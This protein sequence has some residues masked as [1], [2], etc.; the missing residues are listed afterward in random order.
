MSLLASFPK[1]YDAA[2]AERRWTDRWDELGIHR[3]QPASTAAKAGKVFSVDTPPPYVSAAHLHVG[4]AMSYSQAEF[5]VRFQRMRG[6]AVFYPMGFDDNGLPTERYVEQKHKVNKAKVS[7]A[8]FIELCLQETRLG[9]QVYKD[10]WR[11]L[12]L[13]VDWRMTYS[14]IQPRAVRHAQRSFLDLVRQGRMERRQD[15]ILWC[16]ACS[17]ALAQAD[18]EADDEKDR[19]MHAVRFERADGNGDG[20]IETTRPE[21]VPACVA[22]ACHPDDARFKGFAGLR[23]HVPLT[24]RTVPLIRDE[25]VDPEFGTGLMMVCTFGDPEDIAK[26]RKYG[27]ETVLIIDAHGRMVIPELPELHGQR[28]HVQ[29]K[30]SNVYSE[31]RAAAV[32]LLKV[33]GHLL[34]IKG[35]LSRASLHERCSTPVEIQVAPQWFIRLLDL[36]DELLGRGRELRWYPDWMRER[37]ENWVENLRWDW[38]I[39]RQRFYGVPFPVWFCEA[40]QAPSYAPEALLPV[41]PTM[42]PCPEAACS[43]CGHATFRPEPDVMDTWMTSSLTPLLNA[44]WAAW[45][46]D[47]GDETLEADRARPAIYPMG[48]RVQAFEIIRTWLFYTVAK[49]HLHAL[50]VR[51]HVH[52]DAHLPWRDVMISGWGLDRAG[53]KMSKRAGNFVDPAVVIA[54]YGADALRY[55]S[56]GAT[57]GH[58]LRWNED[59]VKAGKRLLTK[60]WNSTRLALI[61]LDAWT[62]GQ[63]PETPTPADRWIRSKLVAVVREATQAFS[64]YEYSKA[65]R[66]VEQCF[67]GDWCDQY[68]EMVKDRFRTQQDGAVVSFTPGEVEA[69]RVTLRDGTWT[70][71]RLFAP[72]LPFLTE[73]LYHLAV[74]PLLGD[75]APDSLHVAPWPEDE[76]SGQVDVFG[77]ERDTE[78][79]RLG[80]LLLELVLAARA[81]KTGHQ[82]GAG[83]LLDTVWLAAGDNFDSYRPVLRDFQATVRAREVTQAEGMEGDPKTCIQVPG[84]AVWLYADPAPQDPAPA[85]AAMV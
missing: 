59:D 73:E 46:D 41:D 11:A 29:A 56:A 65:L 10:L 3:W 81:S 37:Y 12:G 70:L 39:S 53:K 32:E 75:K 85:A 24:G 83:R 50:A 21:L 15:P 19:P 48:V 36:K 6:R 45:D 62:P 8:E 66:A 42:T 33:R 7:R 23:F 84:K 72:V 80:G 4:H 26:W 31:A 64:E 57:L 78:G 47:Q 22:L 79:E 20:V 25:T 76:A 17:T 54:Q 43:T 49:S 51:E 82:V 5:V 16:P 13:S 40:C 35:N 30:G 60:L 34:G 14:T 58:D 18:V 63:V 74:K 69:A 38:N 28:V 55:W 52:R 71:L 67:W 77:G 1:T 61:Y 44:N 9:A 68:L 27:L 2:A